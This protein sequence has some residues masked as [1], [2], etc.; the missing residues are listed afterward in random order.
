M[1]ILDAAFLLLSLEG[2][3]A[4]SL[5]EPLDESLPEESLSVELLPDELPDVPSGRAATVMDALSR[6]FLL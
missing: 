1:C 3:P 6:Q 5:P 2:D 4:E